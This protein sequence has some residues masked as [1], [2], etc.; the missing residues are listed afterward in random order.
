MLFETSNHA[1]SL[2]QYRLVLDGSPNRLNALLGA[3]S[4]AS[5]T[6]DNALAERFYAQAREQT[7]AGNRQ[8]AGLERAWAASR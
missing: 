7:Q 2:E 6:G 3:A 5:R 4:A 1:S 8:R